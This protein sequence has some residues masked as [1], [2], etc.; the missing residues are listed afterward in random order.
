MYRL[1]SQEL[2]SWARD[3]ERRGNSLVLETGG[4][5]ERPSLSVGKKETSAACQANGTQRVRAGSRCRMVL[6]FRRFQKE[7][8]KKIRQQTYHCGEWG[9]GKVKDGRRKCAGGR[10]ENA[11][12]KKEAQQQVKTLNQRGGKDSAKP[13]RKTIRLLRQLGHSGRKR[14]ALGGEGA[15]KDGQTSQSLS[16]KSALQSRSVGCLKTSGEEEAQSKET[17]SNT[18]RKAAI[19][20]QGLALNPLGRVL[21]ER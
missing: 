16:S 19:K 7:T 18:V 10:A 5:R 12:E 3:S 2:F 21:G 15:K 6:L 9:G 17:I 1:L 8:L 4:V 14:L 11:N 13:E 20:S